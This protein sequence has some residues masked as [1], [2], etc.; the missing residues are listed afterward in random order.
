LDYT[1]KKRLIISPLVSLGAGQSVLAQNA[2]G[3]SQE[4]LEALLGLSEKKTR[5]I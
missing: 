2:L 5:L 4:E 3:M 1:L